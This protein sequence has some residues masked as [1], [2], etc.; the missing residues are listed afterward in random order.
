MTSTS[1]NAD[2]F[3]SPHRS[4]AEFTPLLQQE[5]G[6]RRQQLRNWLADCRTGTLSLVEGIDRPT[7][8]QQAHPDFS[9]IGWHL[10]HIAFTEAL[11]ILERTADQP[12]QF[13][14]Y[15]RLFAAGELPKAE[16]QQLPELAEILHYLSTVRAQVLAYLE[17]AP[18]P[19]QERLWLWLLQHESQHGETITLVQQ[20]HDLNHRQGQFTR[21]REDAPTGAIA[22]SQSTQESALASEMVYVAAGAFEMGS[23]AIAAQ[24]NERPPYWVEL[25][26]YWIDRYPVTCAQYAAFMA[27]GGYQNPDWWSPEGWDW[28]QHNPVA[29]PLYWVDSPDWHDHPV[30]GVSWYEADAYARFAG[31]RLP[32]EAEWEKSATW[33]PQLQQKQRYPWG[34]TDPSSIHCNHSH[35]VGHTTPVHS[36]PAG[37]SPSGCEDLLGNVWEWTASGFDGYAGFTPYLYT[38]YSQI[39]FDGKHKVLR[40]GSWATRPW[41][42]RATFRNWYEPDVRQI[43][44][45]FR[46]A[47][48]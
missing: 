8:I 32:T 44:A 41:A 46:C 28:L 31:K 4:G 18:I 13:P 3:R 25:A 33:H 43:L 47:T 6:D 23:G 7:L 2:R 16:R 14:A 12:P 45:G 1:G 26:D 17:T 15:R 11:W 22:L 30:Y 24:D 20:L 36:Y 40:G 27:A 42:L 21:F 38:G 10:G 19:Q 48:N 37:A 9:P 29:Q 34:N 35:Q 39:Y 5:P